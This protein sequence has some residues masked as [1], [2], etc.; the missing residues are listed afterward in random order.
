MEQIIYSIIQSLNSI[1]VKGKDN[2]E[3]LYCA[4]T[5]LEC[6]ISDIQ[7]AQSDIDKEKENG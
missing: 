5:A 7:K 6:L 3:R 4:I 1:E 2:I